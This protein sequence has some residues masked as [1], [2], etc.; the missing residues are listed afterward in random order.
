MARHPYRLSIDVNRGS[1]LKI[2]T[3]ALHDGVSAA[4]LIRELLKEADLIVEDKD[5]PASS[6]DEEQSV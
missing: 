3:K 5:L 4:S 1:F 2:K 6:N